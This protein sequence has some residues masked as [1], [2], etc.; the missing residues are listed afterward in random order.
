LEAAGTNMN[1]D[2]LAQPWWIEDRED[3]LYTEGQNYVSVGFDTV[4]WKA[5][6]KN[7][8]SSGFAKQNNS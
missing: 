3:L 7:V 5:K 1:L 8:A 2:S 4:P 6:N